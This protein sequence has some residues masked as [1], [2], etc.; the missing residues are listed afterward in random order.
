MDVQMPEMDGLEATR[1]ICAQWPPEQRP[2]II[3]LTAHALTGDEQKCLA[4]GMDAYISK[5]IQLGK[6]VAALES[7]GRSISTEADGRSTASAAEPK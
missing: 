5:P 3:A 2:Y 7:S 4:A 1:I 6:L